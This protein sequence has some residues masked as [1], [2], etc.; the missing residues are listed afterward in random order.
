LP[1]GSSLE[2]HPPYMPEK[3]FQMLHLR[4]VRDQMNWKVASSGLSFL[5][6]H[7]FGEWLNE[8]AAA[9]NCLTLSS[10]C[11]P[12]APPSRARFSPISTGKYKSKK[13]GF[14]LCYLSEAN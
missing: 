11:R 12:E 5:I 4:F 10:L 14:R 6:S 9:V 1:D 3:E 7:H 13:I 2:G 8:E